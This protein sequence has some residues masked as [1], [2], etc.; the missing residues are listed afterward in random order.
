MNNTCDAYILGRYS[1]GT[2][3]G[4]VLGA[5]VA[6]AGDAD[7]CGRDE[8]MVSNYYADSSNMIWLC[9][10]TGPDA[11]A[12]QPPVEPFSVYSSK[13]SQNWPNPFSHTTAIKYQVAKAGKISLK[14][15]NIAGQVVRVLANEDKKVGSY[16]VRWN[17]YDDNG[18]R[19][20]NGIYIYQLNIGG[21]SLSKKML[22]L[23]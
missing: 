8:F 22:L 17:G 18:Q 7:G 16:E 4:D 14:V 2:G 20:S 10:Y 19:V 11:V 5:R 23:R 13:L 1:G 21:E 12:G 3:N 6:P 9:K 15:Y